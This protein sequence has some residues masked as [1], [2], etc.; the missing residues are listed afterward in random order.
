MSVR[1][2]APWRRALVVVAASVVAVT[3]NATAQ[4]SRARKSGDWSADPPALTALVDAA[5]TESDLRV[6]VDRYLLDKAALERRYPVPFSP[7]RQAR[8]RAFVQGWKQR[9]AEV[10]FAALNPE[11]RIDY[12]LLRN[13][14]DYDLEMLAVADRRWTEIAALVPFFESLR[15]LQEDRF[16]R[17]RADGRATATM[18]SATADRITEL[19]K[20]L[21]ADAP[22]GGGLATRPGI[23]PVIAA[24]AASHVDA[25]KATLGDWY[26]FYDGYD[27]LFSWWTSEPQGRLTKALTGYADAV[28]LHL[29]GI[30][31]GEPA[32]V[33]G[34][35]LLADGLR[36]D[37]AYEMIPYSPDELIAIGTKEFDWVEAE[38]KKVARDMGFGDDWKAA[39]EQVKTLAPPPGDKPWVIFDIAKYSEAYID[40]MEAV[41]IPPLAKEVWRLEMQTPERQRVNPFFTGGEV[42]R[43][44]YP[45][46]SMSHADKQMSMRGNTPSF[47][48]ATV[49]HEIIPGHHLQTFLVNRF[50]PHRSRLQR[51][52]FW[53]EGWSLYWELLL[54]DRGFPRDNADRIGMLFWRLHRAARIV[55]S[56]NYHLGR[57]SPQ[58]AIDFLVE[59]V[60]HERANAEGE[61]RRTTIDA[62]LYQVAYM[63]GG[64][65]LRALARELVDS[66]K[67][68]LTEFHDRV[69]RGGHMPIELVRAR[70]SGQAV[71]PEMRPTWR[72][73][74]AAR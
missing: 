3:E 28:R 57:W 34:D 17:K 4:T 16:D 5:R 70:L 68:T 38:F 44:S 11:G 45:T 47:N 59:R 15:H 41:T 1:D 67:M 10:D 69:L 23:P 14:L 12:L 54:W 51:T 19:T 72:F 2:S 37:F 39:L 66:K 27:P 71:T 18:L 33:I 65:Q 29:A 36:A 56:L 31:P 55:F 60:G 13:R 52:P 42:T 49:H 46:E 30:K 50:N 43:V 9:L 32:P 8:L 40:R 48:F 20:A 62:P 35:P 22:K 24:R 21:A 73:Y 64:L 74:D 6:A 25:L 53:H 26:A 63:V 7:A 61:V 58:Q